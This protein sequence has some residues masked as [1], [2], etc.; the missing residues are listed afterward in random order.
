MVEEHGDDED[1]LEQAFAVARR[2]V[3]ELRALLDRLP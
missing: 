3:A 1:L 2:L